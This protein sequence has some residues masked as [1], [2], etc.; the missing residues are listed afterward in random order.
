VK[1]YPKT[2][3]V[4][5]QIPLPLLDLGIRIPP[6][7][8]PKKPEIPETAIQKDHS[9]RQP[10]AL[11]AFMPES[12]NSDIKFPASSKKKHR[13]PSTRRHTRLR[14]EKW[15]EKQI[16]REARLWQ[17]VKTDADDR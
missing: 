12:G 1:G 11:Q 4:G 2:L 13:S 16:L 7:M 3:G 15:R 17:D 10:C 5:R 8:D 6:V 9:F 14:A